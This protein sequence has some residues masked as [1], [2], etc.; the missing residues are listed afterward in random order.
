MENQI[1]WYLHNI[2]QLYYCLE[3]TTR[4]KIN[5]MAQQLLIAKIIRKENMQKKIFEYLKQIC[6]INYIV[7]CSA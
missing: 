6:S 2:L 1:T 3:V 5:I 7:L 4:L